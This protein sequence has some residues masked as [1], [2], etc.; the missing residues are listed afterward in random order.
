MNGIRW[1]YD[2]PE[3]YPLPGRNKVVLDHVSIITSHLFSESGQQPHEHRNIGRGEVSSLTFFLPCQQFRV[4]IR[5]REGFP[6]DSEMPKLSLLVCR[7]KPLQFLHHPG[8]VKVVVN[9]PVVEQ[10]PELKA[11]NR[12]KSK[13]RHTPLLI[14]P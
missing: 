11:R 9:L 12:G 3:L 1:M 4:S 7:E 10:E 8:T 6:G 2:Y 13:K 14:G 5:S